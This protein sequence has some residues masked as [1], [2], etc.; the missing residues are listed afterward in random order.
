MNSSPVMV[1]F[2]S[3][4]YTH[5][6]VYKRQPERLPGTHKRDAVTGG[7]PDLQTPRYPADKRIDL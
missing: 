5:L 6:D 3:V 2:S 7:Y 1:S 4:S